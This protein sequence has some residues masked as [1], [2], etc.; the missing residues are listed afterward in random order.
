MPNID[1]L[2][3]TNYLQKPG[4]D[5]IQVGKY[6]E[7]LTPHGFDFK[8]VPSVRDVE[9]REGAIAHIV[10]VDRPYEFLAASDAAFSFG[11]PV[12][13]STIHH[14]QSRITAM[15][16]SRPGLLGLA[17]RLLSDQAE[18]EWVKQA[19]RSRGRD[20]AWLSRQPRG[21]PELRR[22]L[23]AAIED[24]DCLLVLANGEMDSLRL[25]FEL[26]S[27]K[28]VAV[29]PNGVD[30]DHSVELDR[31]RDIDVLLVGRVE[32]RKNQVAVLGALAELGELRIHVIGDLTA[33]SRK[34]RSSFLKIIE[35]SSNIEWHGPKPPSELPNFY[36]R[37][38][39]V[40]NGSFVEVL[41]LVEMEALAYGCHVVG[42][43]YGNTHEYFGQFA[44]FV[45]AET[46][47]RNLAPLVGAA[48]SK[49][50]NIGAAIVVRKDFTWSSVA[51]RLGEQYQQSVDA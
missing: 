45:T 27:H 43:S 19:L 21:E 40:V 39:V 48:L 46:V 36:A 11:A 2:M 1:I 38:K 44:E 14:R 17:S 51:A 49:P 50:P 34:F 8:I 9:L 35:S 41:S 22:R 5:S 28:R 13:L 7:H 18:R 6:I 29:I 4:G 26:E 30:V 33:R 37:A 42:S 32:E 20:A 12:F 47:D 3:R 10:N 23:K 24:T 15:D 25:D 31:P 16:S